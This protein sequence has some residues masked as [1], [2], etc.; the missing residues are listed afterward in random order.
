MRARGN[1]GVGRQ[2]IIRHALRARTIRTL[3]VTLMIL[4]NMNVNI[5]RMQAA[6]RT[7]QDAHLSLR[8]MVVITVRADGRVTPRPLSRIIRRHRLLTLNRKNIQQRRRLRMVLIYI[9]I[10][11]SVTPGQRIVMTLRVDRGTLAYQLQTRTVNYASM[12]QICIFYR[13]LYRSSG[14][15]L[16]SLDTLS[17][18]DTQETEEVPRGGW[19]AI[20][21][22][23]SIA[24]SVRPPVVVTNR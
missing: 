21:S 9:R 1:E 2:L 13:F 7:P 12:R 3:Y 20:V 11:R 19:A 4:S 5:G 18:Q 14:Y 17:P 22:I 24:T 15:V 6:S 8:R 16:Y 10:T 23:A